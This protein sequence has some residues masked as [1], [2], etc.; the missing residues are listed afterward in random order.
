MGTCKIV[1]NYFFSGRFAIFFSIAKWY[2]YKHVF[3]LFR[4]DETMVMNGM[5]GN[6][7][8][9]V[10]MGRTPNYNALK[11]RPRAMRSPPSGA[12]AASK[13]NT[14]PAPNT[15]RGRRQARQQR[16]MQ[17]RGRQAGQSSQSGQTATRPM[18]KQSNVGGHGTG[19]SGSGHHS[20]SFGSSSEAPPPEIDRRSRYLP[21]SRPGSRPR[22]SHSTNINGG[23]SNVKAPPRRGRVGGNRASSKSYTIGDLAAFPFR[24]GAAAASA[25]FNGAK[26]SVRIVARPM[27]R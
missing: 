10:G 6:T 7:C 23:K 25:T 16:R 2:R 11:K 13:T 5:G 1:T 9:V 19:S 17:G 20:N 8:E 21:K 3:L 14:A 24:L 26:Y 12:G 27:R 4:A 15:R 18:Q 22:A